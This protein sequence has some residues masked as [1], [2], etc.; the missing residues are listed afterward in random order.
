MEE[1][2]DLRGLKCPLPALLA[3]KALAHLAPGTTLTV[4]ADDPMSVVDIPHMCHDEGHA[5]HG[6]ASRDGYSEFILQKGGPIP[7]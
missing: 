5:V 1:T 3:K 6:M 2:L 4:L 7:D